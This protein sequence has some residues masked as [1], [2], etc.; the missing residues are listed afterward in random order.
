MV[1]GLCWN[2]DLRAMMKNVGP[3]SVFDRR[4]LIYNVHAY[5]YSFWW[6]MDLLNWISFISLI[7]GLA[8]FLCGLI[9]YHN[10]LS[11]TR[12]F[13]NSK[14]LYA[15]DEFDIYEF[16]A[17][18]VWFHAAWLATAL[19][20]Y[21]TA[22]SSGCSSVASGASNI[23]T[24]CIIL[25]TITITISLCCCNTF[26]F[27]SFIGSSLCWIGIYLFSIFLVTLYLFST[28]SYLDFLNLWAL[29]NRP[30]PVFV[31][32][33]GVTVSGYH[34]TEAWYILWEF[35]RHTYDLDFAFWAFNG[36]RWMQTHWETEIFGLLS[37]DYNEWQNKL[38]LTR[39]FW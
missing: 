19:M 20:Y 5:S 37:P 34:K 28:Q 7:A 12:K 14:V 33:I 16:L 6:N 36:R 30:V 1:G 18:S 17:A 27:K 29:D 31:G 3:S 35:V 39:L 2:F 38:L 13:K 32:E 9:C 22:M 21:V 8:A 10:F 11:A 23:I 24:S 26:Y 25:T 15:W 4:K